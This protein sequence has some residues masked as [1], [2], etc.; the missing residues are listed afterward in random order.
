MFIRTIYLPAMNYVL[1]CIA[2]DEEALQ[3][4]QSK[5]LSVALQKLGLSSSK[6]PLSLRH[7]PTDMGGLD[8]PDLRTELGIAQ[9]RLM[10]N[11]IFK[12]RKLEK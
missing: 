7:G 2:V 11:A 3:Q 12:N 1:P 9:L 8:L 6:T 5:L 10:R 4:V